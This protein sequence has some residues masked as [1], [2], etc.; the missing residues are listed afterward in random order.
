MFSN[1]FSYLATTQWHRFALG[2]F[3]CLLGIGF[4]IGFGVLSADA[5]NSSQ[6]DYNRRL[7]IFTEWQ[8]KVSTT[9]TRASTLAASAGTFAKSTIT[10]PA[11]LTASVLD[12]VKLINPPAFDQIFADLFAEV[13]GISSVQLQSGGVISQMWPP[14]STTLH[15]D[16]LN[17]PGFNAVYDKLMDEGNPL[18]AGPMVMTG[19]Q[20]GYG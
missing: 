6:E 19:V 7:A 13:P 8:M 20:A 4:G 1:F 2:L 10:T 16:V 14:N 5:K 11:N 3:L 9:F 15:F 17:S 18:T 12:R